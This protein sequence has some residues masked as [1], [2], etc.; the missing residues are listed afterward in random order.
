MNI[1]LGITGSVA[2]CLT[3]KLCEEFRVCGDSV[4]VVATEKAIHFIDEQSRNDTMFTITEKDEW[5][6]KKLGDPVVHVELRNWMDILLIAPLTANTLAKM[7]HG[8]CDNL[9]LSIWLARGNKPVIIAPAM[10]TY[11]LTNQITQNNLS[12]FRNLNNTYVID[13][14]IKK[15]ACGDVGIGALAPIDQIVKFTRNVQLL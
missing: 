2:A 11:M 1:L 15:L 10:N 12:N 13:P 3:N 9:L 8:I 6:W 14:I 7:V 5:S 4:R